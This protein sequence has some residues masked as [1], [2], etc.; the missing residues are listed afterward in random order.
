MDGYG[1]GGKGIIWSCFCICMT[2]VKNGW[3]G[4]AREGLGCGDTHR[5]IDACMHRSIEPKARTSN[6][7][8]RNKQVKGIMGV[9]VYLVIAR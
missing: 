9:I 6:K 1:E 2:G 8:K 4:M 7:S 3:D 5:C